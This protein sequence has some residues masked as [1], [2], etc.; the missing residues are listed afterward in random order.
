MLLDER[1][2]YPHLQYEGEKVVLAVGV[3]KRTRPGVQFVLFL[4]LP[5]AS[6][7]NDH[8]LIHIYNELLVISSD[9]SLVGEIASLQ[10]GKDF[11]LYMINNNERFEDI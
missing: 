6:E 9:E 7:L 2:E 8:I 11:V 5:K 10:S 3:A 4:A 1:I